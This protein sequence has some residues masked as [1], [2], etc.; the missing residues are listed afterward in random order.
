[1]KKIDKLI[2]KEVVR[3]QNSINLIPSENYVSQKV[4]DAIGSPLTNKYSE[5]YPGK[6]YYPGNE[7]Y[8]KIEMYVQNLALKAFRLNQKDWSVNIQP[9]SGSPANLAVYLALMSPGDKLLGFSLTS[10][11]HLTHGHFVNYSGKL[12]KVRQ[13]SVNPKTGLLDYD[14]IYKLAKKFKPKL[15]V[16]GLTSY[17]RKIDFKKFGQIA[18]KVGA[19]HLADISHIA[20]LILANLHP[21]PFSYSDV[22]TTTTHKTLRGPR[23]ALIFMRK[24]L[25]E[26]INKSVF[27]GL[28]GGPHNN[29]I[30]GIGVMFE[31]ALTSKFI[32]YQQQILKNAKVLSKELMNLGFTLW[33]NGTDNHLM[34]IDL[35]PLGLNGKIA[36]E[37]LESANILA[38]RN[39][40]PGDTSPFNPTGLRLGTPAVTSRGMKEK[41]MLKIAKFIKELL[42]DQKDPKKI[43]EEVIRFLCKFPLPYKKWL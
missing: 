25:E 16:S 3:Q 12:F 35:K 22:V 32:K 39:A 26:K 27:P 28:Q 40:L 1:M 5:G 9:Y 8:D 30:A 43:K 34:V 11:G 38:N 20:G 7:I 18:K 23:G 4:L 17:P 29:I 10:G 13:Y 19:Y 24:H 41:E 36:E 2:K 6:R 21:A 14:E 31:E 15:I 42:I 33:T 37:I